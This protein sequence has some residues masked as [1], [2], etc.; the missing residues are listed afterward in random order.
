MDHYTNV[1]FAIDNATTEEMKW[2]MDL[3]HN[4]EENEQALSD[5][6]GIKEADFDEKDDYWEEM[7]QHWSLPL[8]FEVKPADKRIWI[9]DACGS[10]D[11]ER[12]AKVL[13]VFLAKFRPDAVI[14]FELACTASR[15]ALY[16]NGGGAFVVTATGWDSLWT[17]E[18]IDILK[19]RMGVK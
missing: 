16:T 15:N 4:A 10:F 13:S 19:E 9:R 8:S 14:E 2:W 17:N 7:E 1:S 3:Q 18:V 11:T 6:L 5:Q 12:M